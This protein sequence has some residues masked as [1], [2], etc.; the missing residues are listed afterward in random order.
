MA[1]ID[2]GELY[3]C[4]EN[5]SEADL[6]RALEAARAVLV[7]ANVTIEDASAAQLA[8]ETHIDMAESLE[9]LSEM[10]Q[11]AVKAWEDA[12]D[13]AASAFSAADPAGLDLGPVSELE[14]VDA[15]LDCGPHYKLRDKDRDQLTLGIG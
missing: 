7:A 10:E 1:S 2:D 4:M 3:L 11:R 12:I 15:D 9:A 5:A 6:Q 13:A 8:R 14:A